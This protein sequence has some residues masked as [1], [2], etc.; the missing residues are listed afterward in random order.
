[1]PFIPHTDSDVAEM[2]AAI[3]VARKAFLETGKSWALST[4]CPTIDLPVLPVGMG[5][6]EPVSCPLWPCLEG[7][8][9]KARPWRLISVLE[10]WNGESCVANRAKAK[11][12]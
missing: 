12:C 11:L 2:L 10:R 8:R 6:P 3:G 7:M 9:A 4:A 5:K 1:M